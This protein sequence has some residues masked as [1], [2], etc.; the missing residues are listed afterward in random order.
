MPRL[1]TGRRVMVAALTE[2]MTNPEASI[3]Q[4][5]E[6]CKILAGLQPKP[7]TKPPKKEEKRKKETGSKLLG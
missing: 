2:I 1:K 6:A 4:K 7:K 5:L 3:D